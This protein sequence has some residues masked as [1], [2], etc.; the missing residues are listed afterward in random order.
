M[1]DFQDLLLYREEREDI[2][3]HIRASLL[4]GRLTVSGHEI[5]EA[6][7]EFWGNDE[8]EYWYAFGPE[9][10]EKLMDVIDGTDDPEGALM[11]NFGGSDG[12]G[13]LREICE[14]NG[15]RYRFDSYV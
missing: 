9:E 14:S 7:A 13:K 6:V 1:K 2:R 15:I 12:C 5:G 11:M 8:Y 4:D 10:T 3:I